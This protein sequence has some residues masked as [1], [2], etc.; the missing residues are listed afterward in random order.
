MLFLFRTN[1]IL[2]S[3]F[4]IIYAVILRYAFFVNEHVLAAMP[5]GVLSE[6]MFDWIDPKSTMAGVISI[7]L[8]VVQGIVINQM[9]TEYRMANHITLFPGLFYILFASFGI[10]IIPFS[11]GLLANTFILLGMFQLMKVYK[12][13]SAAGK[14]F[15]IGFLIS[16]SSLFHFGYFI[17]IIVTLLGL[18]VLR[19]I[20]FK[21]IIILLF[22]LMTPYYLLGVYAYWNDFLPEF[23]QH[24]FSNF[25]FLDVNI[26]WSYDTIAL[27]S[28]YGILLI[29]VLINYS[30][31]NLSKRMHARKNISIVFIAIIFAFF[32]IFFQKNITVDDLIILS[33]YLGILLSFNFVNLDRSWAELFHGVIFIGALILQYLYYFGINL[34]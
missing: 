11:S 9:V 1:Q 20:R 12:E 32:T 22:G 8:I 24:Q 27:F 23:Y 14:I 31:Y 6:W 26:S 30:N 16:I 10:S 15:N 13:H 18:N 5:K 21:E 25:G 7:A 33:P 3:I 4:L 2:L 19:G 34:Q 17:F 29:I 28:L